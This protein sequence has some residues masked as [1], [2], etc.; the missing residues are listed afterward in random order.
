MNKEEQIR[1]KALELAMLSFGTENIDGVWT[2]EEINNIPVFPARLYYRT[3]LI[4]DFL[5]RGDMAVQT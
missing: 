4:R 1:S 3:K 5:T 2:R